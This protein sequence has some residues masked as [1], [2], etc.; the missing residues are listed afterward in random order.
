MA[1]IDYL[2]TFNFE[3]WSESKFKILVLRREPTL[4]SAI[5]P[6]LYAERFIKFM[7]NELLIDTN[8]VDL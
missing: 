4:I 6:E 3:K 7:S 5:D 2:Q 8:L 1:I